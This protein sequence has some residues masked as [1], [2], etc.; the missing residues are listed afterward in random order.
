MTTFRFENLGDGA[1]KITERF[2]DSSNLEYFVRFFE[3]CVAIEDNYGD[4]VLIPAEPLYK[5]L[6]E[7]YETK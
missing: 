5:I 3:E 2:C 6:K 1:F 7:S 4:D